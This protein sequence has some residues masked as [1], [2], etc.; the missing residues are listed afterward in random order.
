[1]VYKDC[2]LPKT[3]D[4][5]V[6][7]YLG[8]PKNEN[9]RPSHHGLK[10][11]QGGK[12]DIYGPDV[13]D[14]DDPRFLGKGCFSNRASQP[15]TID[16]IDYPNV[17]TYMYIMSCEDPQE[18]SK[19]LLDRGSFYDKGSL[20]HVP[21]KNEDFSQ[22]EREILRT[23]VHAKLTQHVDTVGEL[24]ATGNKYIANTS[25]DRLYGT[26]FNG[27]GSN[28]L[29]ETYMD[30]RD[31]ILSTILQNKTVH[32]ISNPSQDDINELAAQF[33]DKHPDEV[34]KMIKE[35]VRQDMSDVVDMA[36]PDGPKK[37]RTPTMQNVNFYPEKIVGAIKDNPKYKSYKCS[38]HFEYLRPPQTASDYH[39]RVH[40]K[41]Q[42]LYNIKE[43]DGERIATSLRDYRDTNPF[44]GPIDF[45]FRGVG[46]IP[47]PAPLAVISAVVCFGLMA[48]GVGAAVIVGVAIGF[49]MVSGAVQ[50]YK[51]A[52][53]N[54]LDTKKTIAATV[55]GAASGILAPWPGLGPLMSALYVKAVEKGLKLGKGAMDVYFPKE[56]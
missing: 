43:R 46:P 25:Q 55:L 22:V 9:G 28:W 18:A 52:T 35:M 48:T 14:F 41:Y 39:D 2:P 54:G 24:L 8:V 19:W 34:E 1:M 6:K 20:T 17:H 27:E 37:F 29:G 15:I 50:A 47:G 42:E 53:G 49:S 26:G 5:R 21:K 4:E 33:Q 30:A 51:S 40:D 23:A 32:P 7:R 3:V 12:V 31:H 13:Y 44:Y 38:D 10:V 16:G 56:R 45:M 11:A 36:Y